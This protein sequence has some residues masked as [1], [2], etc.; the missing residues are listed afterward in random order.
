[1][2]H[3]T[4]YVTNVPSALLDGTEILIMGRYRWQLELL[5][6]LWKS[7]RAVDKWRTNSATRILSEIYAKLIGAIIAPWLLLL[8]TWHKARRSWLQAIPTIQKSAWQLANSL[9]YWPFL[10]HA[11]RSL[12]RALTKCQMDKSRQNPRAFQLIHDP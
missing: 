8:T 4:I 12:Q 6:K 11:L 3:W 1:M 2:A 9:A 10:R 7:H 5:F